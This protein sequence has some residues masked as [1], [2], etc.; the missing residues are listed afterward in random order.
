L[1][2]SKEA[3]IRGYLQKGGEKA[4]YQEDNVATDITS[5]AVDYIEEN[6]S[7]PFFMYF[8]TSSPHD[9]YTP[10]QR[11]RGK[12][13]LGIYGD[14]ITE[15]DWSI[16]KIIEKLKGKGIY[17]ETVI[18][19]TSDN[20][21]EN[22]QRSEFKEY[23]YN[24]NGPWRGHKGQIFEGSNRVPFIIRWPDNCYGGQKSDRLIMLNDILSSFA[25]FFGKQLPD[26]EAPD[27]ENMLAALK[28]DPEANSRRN[29]VFHSR[30]GMFAI[31]DG[32]WKYI[33]GKGDGDWKEDGYPS[34]VEKSEGQL[35][36]LASDPEES[37]NLFSEKPD[38]VSKLRDALIRI[39]KSERNS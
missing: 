30:A 8:A 17:D 34:P 18:I 14:F 7:K 21:G 39:Y 35:Y 33:H 1:I 23:D 9:P 28:G 25:A 29:A 36:D 12:S 16:G 24:P 15:I 10:A 20:G 11:F 26:G 3:G 4:R 38:I 2:Q 22:K 32:N 19:F 13:N 31:R 27:S 6:S 37:T 5:K